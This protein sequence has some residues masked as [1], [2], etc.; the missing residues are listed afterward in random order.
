MIHE[1]EANYVTEKWKIA[2]W[3]YEG[4]LAWYLETFGREWRVAV[5]ISY[6]PFCG[7]KLEYKE[8]KGIIQPVAMKI[9]P[10]EKIEPKGE[11]K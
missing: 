11:K 7:K 6:C 5:R 1:C 8:V 3:E 10:Y 4:T 9:G 2:A